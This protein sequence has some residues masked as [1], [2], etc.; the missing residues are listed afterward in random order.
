MS[1]LEYPCR[2]LGAHI[3]ARAEHGFY[4]EPQWVDRRLF[5]V[6]QFVGTIADRACGLGRI[7]ESARHAGY[8][9]VGTDIVNRGYKNFDGELDFLS[10]DNRDDNHVSNPPF[11]LCKEFTLHALKLTT[12]KVALIW[13]VRRIPAARWLEDTPLARIWM[14]TPRPSMPPGDYILAGKKPGGG[15]QDFAWL[16]FE[17]GHIGPPEMRWLHRDLRHHD[18]GDR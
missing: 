15:T 4:I 6:E 18:G 7:P 12:R 2:P 8:R 1:M 5:E 17:P 13:L 16:V 9:T 14:L 10:S 3:W 11:H